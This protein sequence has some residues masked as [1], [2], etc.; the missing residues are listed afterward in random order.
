MME[1]E[2]TGDAKLSAGRRDQACLPAKAVD[3]IRLNLWYDPMNDFALKGQG[4]AYS[5]P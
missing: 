4:E 2:G 3:Q 5:V 1:R